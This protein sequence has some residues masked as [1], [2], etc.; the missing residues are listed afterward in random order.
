MVEVSI[1]AILVIAEI[2][3]LTVYVLTVESQLEIVAGA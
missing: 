2:R 1:K 3:E